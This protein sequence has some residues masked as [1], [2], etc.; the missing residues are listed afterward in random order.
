MEMSVGFVKIKLQ[1]KDL[2]VTLNMIETRFFS[3]Y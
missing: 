1:T 2:K 3:S